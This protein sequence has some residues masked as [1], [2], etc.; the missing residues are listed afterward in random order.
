[1]PA[2]AIC[3]SE[4]WP[5][6]PVRTV[7]DSAQIAKARIVA[8]SRCRD[9]WVTISGSAMATASGTSRTRRSRFRTQKICRSRSGIGSVLG[10]KENASPSVRSRPWTATTS[11][12]T[13][14]S[15]TS[16]T[17]GWLSVLNRR[18]DSAR[19]DAQSGGEGR[20]ERT[21][22]TD[23]CRHERAEQRRRAER[24]EAAAEPR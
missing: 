15:T 5:P 13:R 18:T 6:H 2:N 21:E 14:S 23:Q 16:A 8:Y 1:M 7:R 17:P 19:P 24:G 20:R 12:T 10:V 11:S 4:S 9:G 22:P 3:P